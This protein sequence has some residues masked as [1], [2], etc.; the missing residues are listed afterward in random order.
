[1]SEEMQEKR[2]PG[3]PPKSEIKYV[4]D[5]KERES[6]GKCKMVIKTPEMAEFTEAIRDG[7]VS[8][9]KR[10]IWNEGECG[11]D[12]DGLNGYC[13]NHTYPVLQPVL[14]DSDEKKTE[15]LMSSTGQVHTVETSVKTHTILNVG[16]WLPASRYKDSEIEELFK[17]GKIGI[18]VENDQV[19]ADKQATTLSADEINYQLKQR[20]PEEVAGAIE[21]SNY[22][23]DTL[24]RMLAMTREPLI[25]DAIRKQLIHFTK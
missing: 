9:F 14:R 5:Q 24:K 20:N 8:T 17:S 13:K 12:A 10:L 16:E 23:Q 4:E 3:R 21:V 19:K 15:R 22:S 25:V 7:G 6:L 11:K 1:M 2:L 18:Q